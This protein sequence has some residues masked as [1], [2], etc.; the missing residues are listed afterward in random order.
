MY[1]SR[2]VYEYIS[3]Q[4][5]DPIVEWKLCAVS[6]TEFPIYKSDV[7]FYTKISS[8]KF[9]IPTPTLCSEERQRRRLSFRNERKLY[10]R[11]CDFSGKEIISMYSPDKTIK[12]YDLA[13]WWSDVWDAKTYGREF[14]FSRNFMDQ[15]SELVQTVPRFN[16]SND[17]QS[18]NSAYVNETTY[19]KNCYYTFDAD[20]DEDCMYGNSIKFSKK[21]IDTSNVYY[22]EQSYELVNCTKCFDCTYCTECETSQFLISCSRCKDCSYCFESENLSN[23]KY[24]FRNQACHSREEYLEKLSSATIQ[25]YIVGN[26]IKRGCYTIQDQGS[27]GNNLAYTKDCIFAYNFGNCQ[28]IKYSTCLNDSKNSMDFDIWGIH[29]EYIYE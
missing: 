3:L 5:K 8:S 16:L 13:I 26:S 4:T 28:N 21:C 11:T 24:Y 17:N 6:G 19:Q 20:Q 2:A 9:L 18:E 22:C 14:D 29:C 7:D 10:R 12:V 1:T 23:K 27:F 25:G 15:F